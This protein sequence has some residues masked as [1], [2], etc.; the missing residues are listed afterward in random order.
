MASESDIKKSS[1]KDRAGEDPSEFENLLHVIFH[2]TYDGIL[3]HSLQGEI[4][5]AN[6][7]F[8]RMYGVSREE[9]LRLTIA[10]LSSPSM[11]LASLPAIWAKTVAGEEQLFEWK[12][13]R[14]N[15]GVEIDVEVH[16][17]R[18]RMRGSAHI[19]ANVRDITHRK[20]TERELYFFK[21][22]VEHSHDPFYIISPA[23]GFRF[24]YVNEAAARHYGRNREELLTMSVP[25]WDLL[26]Q[27]EKLDSLWEELKMKGSLLYETRHRL[28]D[29]REI[30]VEVSANYFEYGGQQL[31]AGWFRD[32]AERRR[33]E[34]KLAGTLAELERSNQDLEQFA[35]TVSHDLQEPL[36]T[37]SGFLNLVRRRYRGRLDEE[38]DRFINFAVEGAERLDRM[39]ID[40]LEYSRVQQQELALQPVDLYDIWMAA[41]HNLHQLIEETGAHITHDRFPRVNGDHGLLMR[42]FQNLLVNAIKFRGHRPPAI[43]IGVYP[44]GDKWLLGVQ[45]N[46]I[47]IAPEHLG[48]IFQVF[49]RLHSR[50]EYPGTGIGLAICRKIVERHGGRIWVESM[51]GQGST[52]FFTLPAARE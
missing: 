11:Q 46:G 31:F 15:D 39:I 8:L 40:L 3:I 22:L 32:I 44:Q 33:V 48:R 12:G 10:D 52:F 23:A 38:A 5:D 27:G 17:R 50:R 29:G 19:L 26:F 6:D 20:E 25:D 16:L 37:I 24:I 45:D 28:A 14:Y 18:V 49:T 43:H 21:Y 9:V 4:V 7:T 34:E 51:P 13:R 2:S 42:L 41:V 1:K 47:G 36:R 30:P 35:H